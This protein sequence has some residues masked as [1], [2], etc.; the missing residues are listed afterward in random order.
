MIFKVQKL[1]LWD[2]AFE[3]AMNIIAKLPTIAG[4]VYRL[5]FNK[6][7]LIN[8]DPS[9]DWGANLVRTLGLP[10]SNQWRVAAQLLD[11]LVDSKAAAS[12]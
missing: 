1:E 6:G 12:L 8:P 7:E 11:P 3:D 5:R 9:L 2:P 10:D 4:Y